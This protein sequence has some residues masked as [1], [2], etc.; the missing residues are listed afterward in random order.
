MTPVVPRFVTNRIARRPSL[1]L[2]YPL[3][4][5]AIAMI[6]MEP[7]TALAQVPAGE[8]TPAVIESLDRFQAEQERL[9]KLLESKPKAYEDRFL[10]PSL[11]PAQADD[12]PQGPTE[13]T[14][15]RGHVIETRMNLTHSDGGLALRSTRDLG[16]RTEYRRET[17]NYGDFV[18]QLDARNGNGE[19]GS[20]FGP[21]GLVTE[22]SSSRITL[23]NVGLPVTTRLFADTS[24]G[25]ISSEVT[26]ALSRTYRL[27]LGTGIVRGAGTH[28]FDGNMDLRLGIGQRGA[29]AGGPYPAFQRSQGMLAWAGY[30]QR[31]SDSSYAGVQFSRATGVSSTLF[32]SQGTATDD[33]TSAAASVGTVGEV[34][35]LGSYKGRLMFVNSRLDSTDA[36]QR[37]KSQGLFLEGSLQSGRH[38]HEFGIYQADTDLR[39]GDNLLLSGNRGAYWRMDASSLRS[40]WGLGLTLEDVNPDFAPGRPATRALGVSANARH[41]LGRN[42]SVGGNLNWSLSRLRSGNAPVFSTAGEGIRSFNGG[43]FYETRPFAALGPSRLRITLH[44]NEVLVANDIPATGD[45]VE[46]E[47][48][49]IGGRFETLRPEFVTTLGIARDGSTGLTEIRPTAGASFRVWP[50]ADWSLGGSLR[51]T[52]RRG[53]LA[54]SRGLSG[55]IDSE[56]MFPAGWR[57]GANVSLNQA[58]VNLSPIGQTA[59][60]VSRSNDRT[61]SVYLR[62]EGASGTPYQAAGLRGPGSPGGGSLDGIV[63]FDANRDGEQQMGENGVP[64]VEVFLDGRYRV[65]T[66]RNGRFLFAL[67]ATGPHQLTLSAESVPLPWGPAQNKGVRVEVPLRG[68][69]TARMP[70]VRTAD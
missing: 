62:W 17:L 68:Q 53:N 22:K 14:G 60:Q 46:W 18:F 39:F 2:F 48:D 38:H 50:A 30:S 16:I 33:V 57:L 31:L 1:S 69:T 41:R 13:V 51:Y 7:L 37:P 67:V 28:L 54:T 27:S 64:G 45:E 47:Q 32:A 52:A 8:G 10:D 29:L 21:L 35:A 5:V 44:R 43:L 63:F 20:T 66:D 4:T 25:D 12:A 24:A 36:R 40:S 23:R 49:W 58:V 55:T 61:A 9:R 26:D 6:G 59:A 3:A 19:L 65:T 56:K 42:D 34:A 11:A 70:V 15:L